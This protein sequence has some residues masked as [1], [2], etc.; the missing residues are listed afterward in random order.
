MEEGD[1]SCPFNHSPI[2]RH[3]AVSL[4]TGILVLPGD[5][6][7]GETTR[8]CRGFSLVD[9]AAQTGE[10]PC[11]TAYRMSCALVFTFSS[12]MIRDLWYSIVLG[13]R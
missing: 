2:K 8:I 4:N 1:G 10:M 5:F 6:V 11:L 13:V 12:S 7:T 3:A 9:R